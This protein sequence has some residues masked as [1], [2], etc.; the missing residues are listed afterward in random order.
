[1]TARPLDGKVPAAALRETLRR[2]VA[3]RP[4]GT[5]PPGL[6]IVHAGDDAGAAAYRR[7]LERQWLSVGG[8]LR[9]IAWPADVPLAVAEAALHDLSRDPAVHG[10][11]IQQPLPAHLQAAD[12]WRYLD[13]AKDAE[14]MHP[15]N[16]GRR[17]LGAHVPVPCTALAV[18]HLLVH[19]GIAVAGRHVVVVGRSPEVGK[20]IAHEL[21][22]ADATVTVCHSRTADLAGRCREADILVSAVGRPGLIVP[23]MVRPG[24]VVVDVATVAGPDGQLV[25]DVDPS[26]AD[27][28]GWLSPVPGGVGPLTVALL[29]NAVVYAARRGA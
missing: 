29:M 1:M 10:V 14:G 13:P 17:W 3:S 4:A 9:V 11:L 6:A 7:Q 12:V 18:S 24:A 21:L 22:K 15:L 25:G 26:V 20:A 5:P 19:H 27:V 23:A 28:A 16:L 8:G 2:D